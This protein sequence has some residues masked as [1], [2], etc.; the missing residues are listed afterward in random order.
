MQIKICGLKKFEDAETSVKSGADFIG[1]IFVPGS[2]REVSPKEV[3]EI[4]EGLKNKFPTMD[5][6]LVGL[7]GN[8]KK[9]EIESI[10]KFTSIDIAQICGEDDIDIGYPSI[11][12]I[13]IKESHKPSDILDLVQRAL[14][15]HN[16]AVLD[17]Y[18]EKA[19]GG[20]GNSFSWEKAS[21]VIGLT[22]VFVSGGLNC[23]N[24]NELS[25]KY[26]PYGVDVSSG[27][28]TRGIKDRN[29]I[30]EFIKIAK[31]S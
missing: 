1:F 10:I 13:R 18:N 14:L 2:K 8:Q 9:S 30:E 28:E 27:V 15:V 6:K 22:N 16:Y 20:T 21:K 25:N 12:Q 17:S 31:N 5:T 23:E 29:K 19:L 4:I 26:H 24:I 3:F 11:R 7:F